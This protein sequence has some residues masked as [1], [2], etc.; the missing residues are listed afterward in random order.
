MPFNRTSGRALRAL[1][2]ALRAGNMEVRRYEKTFLHAKAYIFT[3]EDERRTPM[4]TESSSARR[5]SRKR[6]SPETSSSTSGGTSA[7]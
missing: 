2:D 4:E 7:R 6:G 5:T 1:I 3:L